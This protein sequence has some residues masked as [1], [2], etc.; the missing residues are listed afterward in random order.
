MNRL[1]GLRKKLREQSQ[2]P[3]S[4]RLGCISQVKIGPYIPSRNIPPFSP[5]L[6][7][8]CEQ[9]NEIQNLRS[10][11]PEEKKEEE[12][13]LK[14]KRGGKKREEKRYW[15]VSARRK[16][17][18]SGAGRRR[19]REGGRRRLPRML[20]DCIATWEC[21]DCT[22]ARL[23]P[24]CTHVH[25]RRSWECA[26][27]YQHGK[28][29]LT[30]LRRPPPAVPRRLHPPKHLQTNRERVAREGGKIGNDPPS[31]ACNR[32]FRIGFEN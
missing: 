14:I 8:Y 29:S 25:T 30:S 22:G 10:V 5:S 1:E 24:T 20:R 32:C 27:P 9:R 28:R 7:L 13:G 17:R 11:W 23:A 26:D 19:K 31:I 21:N 16:E 6:S 2:A 4:D 3:R 18:R 12:E 15:R